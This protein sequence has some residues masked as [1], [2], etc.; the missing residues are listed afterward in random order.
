MDLSEHPGFLYVIAT[1]LPRIALHGAPEFAATLGATLRDAVTRSERT[2]EL[3]YVP[4]LLR[5]EA[6][7]RSRSGDDPGTVRPLLERALQ[8]ARQH[9]AQRLALRISVDLEALEASAG[10]GLLR[11]R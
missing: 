9:G 6:M 3:W 5:L 4:E 1:L 2:G 8:R 7:V 10:V 11:V